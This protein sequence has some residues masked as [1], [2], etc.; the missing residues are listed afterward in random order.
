MC[1]NMT[2]INTN[3]YKGDGEGGQSSIFYRFSTDILQVFL[4]E[5][6]YKGMKAFFFHFKELN[7][8]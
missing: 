1:A 3:P 4:F 8:Y 7:M 2:R 6:L 5:L